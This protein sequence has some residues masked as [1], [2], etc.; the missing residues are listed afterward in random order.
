MRTVKLNTRYGAV[1]LGLAGLALSSPSAFA[2]EYWLRAATT[3]VDMPHPS[4]VGTTPVAMW[5]YGL[6]TANFAS[7]TD[8]I[9]VPGPALTVPASGPDAQTLIV[10]LRNDL[11]KV[12]SLVINGLIKASTN[13]MAPVWTELNSST[14]LSTRTPTARVRSFDAEAAAGGGTV[15]Y[16]WGS[17]TNP[18]P[19]GTYLYQSGTNPQVQVQMGLYG[20][21]AKNQ[22]DFDAGATTAGARRA[23]A[24]PGIPSFY[25]QEATLLYS[26]IDPALHAAVANGTYGTTG[27]TSTF[28]YQPKYFLINGQPYPNTSVLPLTGLTTLDGLPG[29][30]RLRLLN[31]GLTTHVPMIQGTHWTVLA[32]DGKPYPYSFTQYTALLSA[33]KTMDV[34]LT[35]DSG[36]GTYPIMDRRLGLSNN[37]LSDGG[38]LAYL[39]YGAAGLAGDNSGGNAVPVATDDPAYQAVQGVAMNVAAPGVLANDTDADNLPQPIR[40]V[41][42]VEQPTSQGG[43]Y[44]LNSN[45]SFVYTPAPGF[46]GVDTFTYNATDGKAL[47]TAAATVTI[48]VATPTAPTVAVLDDFNRGNSNITN[49]LGASWAQTTASVDGKDLLI[50]SNEA[51]LVGPAMSGGLAIW[52]TAFGATQYAVLTSGTT[53]GALGESAVILKASGGTQP[54]APANLIRVR[55][56]YGSSQANDTIVVST[57]MGGSNAGVYVKQASFPVGAGNR[58][59]TLLAKADAKGLVTVFKD[60]SFVGGV[61]LPQIPAWTGGGKVGIQLLRQGAQ[62]DNFGGGTL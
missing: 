33:A 21:L 38:M 9:T 57:L 5:G 35:P 58:T 41:A 61:Q 53:A 12:T 56:E 6:C 48:T 59:G 29:T 17:A 15:I 44:T 25:E 42:A 31:A 1:A 11:P 16:T 27:P 45:G 30:T 10:H 40:A 23:R 49:G 13:P 36:G 37:G 39:Q 32:E 51:K 52:D 2:A 50:R 43:T 14:P 4:G 60:G 22:R 19:P 47:S 46:T 62:V 20:A 24:Y 26:E 54:S 34:L 8:P 28:D 18:V 3:T 55:L 7:C